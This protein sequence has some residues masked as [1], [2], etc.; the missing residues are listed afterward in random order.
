MVSSNANA[1]GVIFANSYD[2]L[3]PELVAERTMGSIPFAGRYRM[4]DF[5]L[6]NMANAGIDNVSVIVRKNYHSLMDHLGSGREWDLTRKRGGL[7]IV[8]PFA[9]RS[10]K[11]YSGRVDALASVLSWLQAQKERY[12]ILSD[13]NVAMNFDFN[14]LIDA[15]VASGADVTMVY[16]RSEIPDGARNDNYTIRIDNGRVTE[17]L[18]NDYRPGVQNLSLNLYIIER[19]TLIQLIRDAAV[20]GLV[21]FERDILARNLNLLN[22]QAYE[23]DGYAARIADMK[24]YFDENM[25][26]LEPGNVDKLFDPANPIYT[27]IRDDN[28]TRY[29][30]GSKVKNSLLADGCVIEGTVEN[31]V[32]F[33]GCQIK[34]GA[35]VRNC[36]L[37]QDTVVEEGCTVEYVVSDKNVHITSGKQLTGTDSFPV[38]VAKGHTV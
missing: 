25:R 37:M 6:S 1:L 31:S 26:L 29:L 3:V 20:R 13:T 27:K 35:V 18:S 8:P 16:N 10:V 14:K 34:K 5:V 11:L 22:V 9:E 33:R 32:L 2:N 36:V 28:P 24:S 30:E 38:F 7:N 12:V 19:E 23:F 4:I 21:Y 15:H 17:L